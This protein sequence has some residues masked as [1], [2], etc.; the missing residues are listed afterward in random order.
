[1]RAENACKSSRKDLFRLFDLK[2]NW[3]V[4]KIWAKLHNVKFD[5]NPFTG[6]TVEQ[7]CIGKRT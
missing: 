4:Q 6:S 1:M 7:L 5:K 2:K 3:N